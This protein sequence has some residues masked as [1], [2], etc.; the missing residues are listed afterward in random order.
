MAGLDAN[1]VVALDALLTECGVTRAAERLHTSPAAMSRTL[2]RIRRGLGDPV[3]DRAGQSMVLTPRALTMRDEV[4]AV[5]QRCQ[6]LLAPADDV[7]PATLVRTFTVQTSDLLLA[8]LA[9]GLREATVRQAP[10]VSVILRWHHRL[11]A[12]EVDVSPSSPSHRAC[13]R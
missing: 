1:L 7:D 9:S 4:H 5:V 10:G 13:A 6:R 12:K 2:G 3:L 8:A 11:V